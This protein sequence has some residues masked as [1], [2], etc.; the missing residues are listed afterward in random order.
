MSKENQQ[1]IGL[2]R[3]YFLEL[4]TPQLGPDVL[5]PMGLS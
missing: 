1:S 4:S 2:C 5:I 3:T